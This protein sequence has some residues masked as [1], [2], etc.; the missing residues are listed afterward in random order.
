MILGDTQNFRLPFCRLIPN[1]YIV[2]KARQLLKFTRFSD[3][4]DFFPDKETDVQKCLD[5]Y[6][7]I[8]AECTIKKIDRKDKHNC[9]TCKCGLHD[10]TLY[11]SINEKYSV[12]VYGYKCDACNTV[13]VYSTRYITDLLRRNTDSGGRIVRIN[14]REYRCF[15]DL[16]RT[17]YEADHQEFLIWIKDEQKEAKQQEKLRKKS[18]VMS[19][20]VQFSNRK[21][22]EYFIVNNSNNENISSNIIYYESD[23]GLELLTAA[24]VEKRNKHG[25]YKGNEFEVIDKVYAKGEDFA[26]YLVLDDIN[27]KSDGGFASSVKNS[28]QSMVH[29]LMYSPFTDRLEVWRATLD[30]Y[31]HE[32]YMDMFLFRKLLNKYGNPGIEFNFI[33]KDKSYDQGSFDDLSAESILKVMGYSVA[34]KDDLSTKQRRE[35]LIPVVSL[36]F[37]V[38]T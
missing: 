20:T 11:L 6:N 14:G 25:N 8:L 32:C 4:F 26:D 23:F 35:L 1:H 31:E 27:I 29:V 38:R 34:S 3:Q 9:P 37:T 28:W 7:E 10:Q 17:E 24:C 12:I 19:I 18:A 22:E 21:N 16:D 36:N 13:Y 5:N 33:Y 2:D 30:R 15:N